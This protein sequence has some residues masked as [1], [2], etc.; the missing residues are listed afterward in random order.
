MKC[1]LC[2]QPWLQL[3]CCATTFAWLQFQMSFDRDN[4][5]VT[6]DTGVW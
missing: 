4:K 2:E 5:H 1:R 6:I 3:I